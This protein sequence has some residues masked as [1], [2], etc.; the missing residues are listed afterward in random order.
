MCMG[1]PICSGGTYEVVVGEALSDGIIYQ[2][3]HAP[4]TDN[5]VTSC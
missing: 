4:Q 2:Q 3:L 1:N 5:H